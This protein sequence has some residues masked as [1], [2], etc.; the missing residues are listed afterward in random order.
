MHPNDFLVRV[1]LG[2]FWQCP[3]S[4]L[5]IWGEIEIR[6]GVFEIIGINNL[7]KY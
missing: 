6:T 4:G 7:L 1:D 3:Y 2:I 5:F